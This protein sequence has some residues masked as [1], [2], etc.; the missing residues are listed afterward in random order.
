M[1]APRTNDAASNNTN[2]DRER[3]KYKSKLANA[4]NEEDDPLAAYHQFVQWTIK[5]YGEAD[6]NSGLVDLLKE[7][8]TQF[9]DDSLYK[10]DL[11]YLKMWALYARQAK[12]RSEAIAIYADLVKSDI[13]TSYSAL[14][15]DYA[16]LLEADGRCGFCWFVLSILVNYY[17]SGGRKQKQFIGRVSNDL[18]GLW[19]DS[20]QD[21][22]NFNPAYHRHPLPL[23][24]HHL[25][26]LQTHPRPL[27]NE[28]YLGHVRD[29]HQVPRV[30]HRHHHQVVPLLS[31][32][33]QPHAMRSCS[34]LRPL[35]NGLRSC[36]STSLSYS[37][38]VLNTA[39][40]RLVRAQKVFLERNGA[41][42][43]NPNPHVSLPPHHHHQ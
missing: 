34:P 36:D 24:L 10:T 3:Q 27:Y 9:K 38:R 6:P 19:K 32:L 28:I 23:L 31:P 11:R 1:M 41:L 2:R 17:G 39:Y 14:Y 30:R 12:H 18:Q 5:N 26:Y 8:T 37:A 42:H 15:E 35:G 29:H 7:A 40:K 16:G 13:G 21:I 43:L 4:L 33:P 25:H 22:A 20:K